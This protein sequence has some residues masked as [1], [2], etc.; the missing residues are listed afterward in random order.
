MPHER[1]LI[2]SK[3]ESQ[4]NE[5]RSVCPSDEEITELDRQ[6]PQYAPHRV[7]HLVESG[8]VGPEVAA[9]VKMA[10]RIR[11]CVDTE[12]V[13]ALVDEQ[14]KLFDSLTKPQLRACGV[15]PEPKGE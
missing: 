7:V 15:D 14:D 5:L 2:V 9:F 11:A 1:W 4:F 12:V 6:W 3:D 13:L 8:A 10:A